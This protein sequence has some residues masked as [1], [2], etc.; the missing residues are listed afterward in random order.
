[1]LYLAVSEVRQ[2]RRTTVKRVISMFIAG[3]MLISICGFSAE[4]YATEEKMDNSEAISMELN[5]A[6]VKA[7]EDGTYTYT[8]NVEVGN[9]QIVANPYSA[10][11]S[12]TATLQGNNKTGS[13][14]TTREYS[15]AYVILM[16]DNSSGT[17]T[18]LL[19]KGEARYYVVQGSNRNLPVNGQM[20][21]CG[22]SWGSS[23]SLPT[24]TWQITVTT[25][26]TLSGTTSTLY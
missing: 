16:P 14:R 2:E 17:A 21:T 5:V 3:L 23:V 13:I 6:E 8:Y 4:A 19:K 9:E 12:V 20:L 11:A 24:G 7:N 15:H 1:M 26:A 18:V 25:S 10:N 22:L